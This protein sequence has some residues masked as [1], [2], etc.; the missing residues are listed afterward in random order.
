[1]KKA[2]EKVG[3]TLTLKQEKFCQLYARGGETY[4]HGTLS[5]ARAYG[6]EVNGTTY[7]TVQSCGSTLLSKS[8]IS[9]RINE[10]LESQGLNDQFADAQLALLLGQNEDKVAKL[11][12]LREYNKLKA[13]IVERMDHTTKGKALP[14]PQV[15]LPQD[16]PREKVGKDAEDISPDE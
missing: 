2:H 13:R 9:N 5:Y 6:I 14:A 10:L 1:M 16:L 7:K 11:G 15:Y 8:I 3:K 12:A 4:G